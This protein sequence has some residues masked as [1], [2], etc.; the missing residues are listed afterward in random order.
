MPIIVSKDCTMTMRYVKATIL[1]FLAALLLSGAANAT[2]V[3]AAAKGTNDDGRGSFYQ[4]L[5]VYYHLDDSIV[6][7][8]RERRIADEDLA[9]VFYLAKQ[10]GIRPVDVVDLRL[11]KKSWMELTLHFGLSPEIYFVA[12]ETTPSLPYS[13]ALAPFKKMPRT[14]WKKIVLDDQDIVNLVNLRFVSSGY[15]TSVD[16]VMRLRSEGKNFV[17]IAKE[18]LSPEYKARMSATD[19][20]VR[21]HLREP[22]KK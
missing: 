4:T 13:K 11:L 14:E 21:T 1:G 5:G 22:K 15:R 19:K 20:V 3:T 9:V 7:S 6:T 10:A 12:A 16:E 18:I 17:A 2:V 8:T